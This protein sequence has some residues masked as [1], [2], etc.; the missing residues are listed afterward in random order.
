MLLLYALIF[1]LLVFF[2]AFFSS[3][4]TALLS[5]NKIKLHLSAKKKNKKAR[6]LEKILEKPESFFSTILIG[7]NFVNIGAASISTVLF[8]R[9]LVSNEQLILLTSTLVTT[10]IILLF[11]EIIPKSY[12]FRHNEKMSYLYVYP[13]KFFAYLFYPMAK[14]TTFISNL[15]FKKDNAP[16]GE[17]ELTLEEIKHFLTSQSKLFRYNPEAL[18]MVKEIIDIAEKDIKSIMNPRLNII[19]LEENAGIDELKKIILGKQITKIPIYADNLDNITGI[20]HTDDVLYTLLEMPAAIDINRLDLKKLTRPP[21][22]ISEYSSLNYA[23]KQFK[24]HKQNMA[25][26]IDEYGS[27]IGILT[28]NDIFKE[29]LGELEIQQP[30]IRKTGKNTYLVNG[31][32]SVDEVNEQLHLHLPDKPDYTTMSGLF[33]YHFGKFPK[34]ENKIKIEDTLLVVKRMGKRKIEEIRLVCEDKSI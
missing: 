34:E 27:T 8:T 19:A 1:I 15:F 2:S 21:I 28:L 12:A 25:V 26:I 11:A 9:F 6:M 3:A 5:L 10:I 16:P 31:N 23:W 7:N 13:L 33:I 17:K 4:E 24:K 20:I 30:S 14:V 29:I 18:R 32:T 22:F